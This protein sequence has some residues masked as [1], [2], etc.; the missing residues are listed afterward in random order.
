MYV[1][2]GAVGGRALGIS[3]W[4]ELSGYRFHEEEVEGCGEGQ[5]RWLSQW[6]SVREDGLENKGWMKYRGGTYQKKA[7]QNE[8]GSQTLNDWILSPPPPT[9]GWE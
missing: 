3:E 8:G 9:D 1:K 5:G 6:I 2:R 4:G 7:I